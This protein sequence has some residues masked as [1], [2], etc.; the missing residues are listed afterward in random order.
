M[1]DDSTRSSHGVSPDPHGINVPPSWWGELW[2]DDLPH[3]QAPPPP[4]HGRSLRG[5]SP[6]GWSQPLRDVPGVG[7]NVPSSKRAWTINA[8]FLVLAALAL[9][10]GLGVATWRDAGLI[11]FAI[12]LPLAAG[13]ALAGTRRRRRRP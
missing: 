1:S 9:V 11:A 2:R 12:A 6:E 8:A 7:E 3:G 13:I 5:G 10:A 4:A